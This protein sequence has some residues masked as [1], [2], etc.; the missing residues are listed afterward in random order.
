MFENL[1]QK[2]NKST[3]NIKFAE[4][5]FESCMLDFNTLSLGIK[6]CSFN[7]IDTSKKRNIAYLYF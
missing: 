6:S 5:F 2:S 3:N 7:N 4:Y 1:D